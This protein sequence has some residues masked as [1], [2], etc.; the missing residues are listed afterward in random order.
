MWAAQA[1]HFS[2]NYRVILVD[3]P[4][5]GESDG[6]GVFALQRAAGQARA[7]L[8]AVSFLLQ[9]YRTGR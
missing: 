1:E 9:D 2:K 6:R 5:H 7:E 3:P 4:G 8:I